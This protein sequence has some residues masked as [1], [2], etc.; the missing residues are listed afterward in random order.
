MYVE[1]MV[2]IMHKKLSEAFDLFDGDKTKT[3]DVK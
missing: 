3:V 2:T 1:I